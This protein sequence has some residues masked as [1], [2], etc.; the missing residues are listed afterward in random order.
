MQIQYQKENIWKWPLHFTKLCSLFCFFPFPYRSNVCQHSY[1]KSARFPLMSWLFFSIFC[2]SRTEP[3]FIP[4]IIH[5]CRLFCLLSSWDFSLFFLN[6][7]TLLL[8][9]HRFLPP[10]RS[11]LIPYRILFQQNSWI[12]WFLKL[13]LNK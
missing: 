5:L 8:L 11:I 10:L 7:S 3:N 13:G 6:T 9:F 2:T 12:L 4:H 1:R